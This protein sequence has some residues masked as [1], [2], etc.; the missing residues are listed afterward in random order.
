[1]GSVARLL[2]DRGVTLVSL[3]LD[4]TLLDTDAAAAARLE[5]AVHAVRQVDPHA[6]AALL[7]AAFEAGLKANPIVGGRMPAFYEALGVDADSAQARAARGGYNGAL[8]DALAWMEGAEA[9]L[10]M[11]RERYRVGVVTNGPTDFQWSKLNKFG[12]KDLVDYVVVSGDYGVHKPDPAIFR[13][14]LDLAGVEARHAAHVGDSIY[15]DVAGARAAGLTAIWFPPHLREHDDPA[16][17]A[18]DG[19]I[20][21]LTDLLDD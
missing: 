12:I 19:I 20:D 13:H 18:P 5:A 7:E 21:S 11:L 8:L 14:L 10:G 1:M 17:E 6:D 15:T 4:D 16:H 3:D 2:A 9:I